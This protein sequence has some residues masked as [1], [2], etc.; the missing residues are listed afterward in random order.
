MDLSD[1]SN[2]DFILRSKFFFLNIFVM[3]IKSNILNNE[4][5]KRVTTNLIEFELNISYMSVRQ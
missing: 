1:G 3:F 4:V 5:E 2:V